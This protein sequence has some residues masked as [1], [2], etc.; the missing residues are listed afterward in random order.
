MKKLLKMVGLLLIAG[1]LFVGCSDSP[2]DDDT[3]KGTNNS[4]SSSSAGSSSSASSSSSSS[5]SS[6]GYTLGEN[7]SDINE[8][9]ASITLADGTWEYISVYNGQ[10]TSYPST[11]GVRRDYVFSIAGNDISLTDGEKM[12]FQAIDYSDNDELNTRKG[13]AETVAQLKRMGGKTATVSV[14]GHTLKLEISGSLS[15]TELMN[16]EPLSTSD[17]VNSFPVDA[18]IKTNS[19]NT[20]YY[21]TWTD[22]YEEN[23]IQGITYSDA[24]CSA[25]L[26]KN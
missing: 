2:K 25:I 10:D 1:V 17:F 13:N 23:L 3:P 7:V 16:E 12:N 21:I 8:T 9:A 26:K 22:D 18:V 19:N 5:S 20:K 4:S 11:A 24:A 14:S 15:S 6:S